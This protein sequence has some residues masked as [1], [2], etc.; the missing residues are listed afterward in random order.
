MAFQKGHIPWNKGKIGFYSKEYKEKLSKAHKGKKLSNEHKKKISKN[1]C[2]YWLGK[3]RYKETKEKI[4]KAL[5]G[6]KLPEVIKR[7]IGKAN[8]GK[9]SHFWKGGITPLRTLVRSCFKYRQW[10]SDI[11]TKDNFTCVLCRKRG[12]WLEVDH[13][14]KRFSKILDEYQIKSLEEAI[15]CEE[16]WNINNG[17]TLC[18]KCHN[19]T[20]QK[21]WKNYLNL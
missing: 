21:L 15:N 6:K 11:F 8:K 19:K 4:S 17:R 18:L 16:L 2:L 7:K 12:G 10:R 13:Y 20:K 14:P 1:N 9:K 3:K 5:T